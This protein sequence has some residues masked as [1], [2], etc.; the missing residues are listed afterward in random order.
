MQRGRK[1]IKVFWQFPRT[2]KKKIEF[3]FAKAI[4]TKGNKIPERR[5]G[6]YSSL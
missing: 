5:E 2:G 1:V 6:G 4:L 3:E